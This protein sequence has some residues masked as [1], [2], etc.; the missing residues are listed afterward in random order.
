MRGSDLTTLFRSLAVSTALAAPGG[1][2]TPV[3][4]A[5]IVGGNEEGSTGSDG[6]E[7]QTPDSGS[8]APGSTSETPQTAGDAGDPTSPSTT[9][10][11]TSSD[12]TT[13]DDTS[14]QGTGSDSG[15]ESSSST[16]G[17]EPTGPGD[18]DPPSIVDVDPPSGATGVFADQEVVITFSEPMDTASVES[19]LDT[20]TLGPV[21]VS[22]NGQGTVVTLE[23]DQALEYATGSSPIAV[24]AL[25]FSI[26][27]DTS[28][29]DE[30]GLALEQALN[31][32]FST[33]RRITTNIAH[34]PGYTGGVTS[35]G[36][37]QSGS[38]D[39]P[40]V[41]DHS[42]N[43]ARRGFMGFA[44]TSLPASILEIES[45]QL[46]AD[47]WLVLGDPIPSLGASISLSHIAPE[48]LP[49]GTYA[50]TAVQNLGVWSNEDSE[51]T[52]NTKSADV[53]TNVRFDYDNGE[54]HTQYRL[55]FSTATNFNSTT[56]RVRYN[57]EV[58]EIQYLLP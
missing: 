21:S 51:S 34:D 12:G 8:T 41:G 53:T 45:A 39:D 56:D 27:L 7:T 29:T 16:G 2:F 57:D 3:D 40:I 11:S 54:T 35:S 25:S 47:Q 9:S 13:S 31:T 36:V 22:W 50:S 32:S 26:S 5:P 42:D 28:A 20:S 6:V 14:A 18:T 15:D 1:C 38:G 55:A 10:Q 44:I 43:T 23:P 30:A 17:E 58:L 49:G 46:R 37:L 24:Q 33:A 48:Q 4:D 52:E 19:A